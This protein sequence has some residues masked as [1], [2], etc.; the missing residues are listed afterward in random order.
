MTEEG[1]WIKRES[2]GAIAQEI[3]ERGREC[4]KKKVPLHYEQKQRE[5]HS[6][7]DV[8]PSAE[9][10]PLERWPRTANSPGICCPNYVHHHWG[11]LVSHNS[12]VPPAANHMRGITAAAKQPEIYPF[13]RK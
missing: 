13:Y 5:L 7:R 4:R 10:E 12:H 8:F 1:R 3:F 6:P 2:R 11:H 9:R